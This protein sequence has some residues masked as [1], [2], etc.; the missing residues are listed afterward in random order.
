MVAYGTKDA[1]RLTDRIEAE[2]DELLRQLP[3]HEEQILRRR[4]GITDCTRGLHKQSARCRRVRAAGQIEAR[5][6][7]KLREMATAVDGLTNNRIDRLK[8]AS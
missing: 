5:A 8:A 4:F 2:A 1:I 6:L 3:R 7:R